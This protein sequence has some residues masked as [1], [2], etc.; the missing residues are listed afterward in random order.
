MHSVNELC[1]IFGVIQP[2]ITCSKLTIDTL[3]KGATPERRLALTL[4]IFHASF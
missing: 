2:A 1:H 3:E 4:N